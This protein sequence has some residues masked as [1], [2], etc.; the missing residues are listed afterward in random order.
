VTPRTLPVGRG[1]NMYSANNG[2]A[3]GMLRRAVPTRGG[4]LEIAG[5]VVGSWGPNYGTRGG[6]GGPPH[7]GPVAA[8]RGV[9]LVPPQVSWFIIMNCCN[10]AVGELSC[11]GVTGKLITCQSMVLMSKCVIQNIY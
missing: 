7:S 1:G 8:H 11:R 5:V 3:R 6:M 10:A 9:R 4:Q 2:A